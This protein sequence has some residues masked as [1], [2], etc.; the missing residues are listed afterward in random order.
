VY[1]DDIDPTANPPIPGLSAQELKELRQRGVRIFAP[2]FPALLE[3]DAHHHV[4][5]SHYARDIR[6]AGLDIITWTFERADLRNGA[7]TAGFYYTFDPLGKAIKKDSDMY[8]ALDVLA[9]DVGILGIFS[10]WP[11]TVTYYA[12]CMGL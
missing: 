4:V 2:P 11:A 9:K 12:N 8:L 10:D 7:A 5:P 6:R 1:L 3:V